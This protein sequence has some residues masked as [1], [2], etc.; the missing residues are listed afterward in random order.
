M[1]PS[2]NTPGG[3]LVIHLEYQIPAGREISP[4]EHVRILYGAVKE[5]AYDHPSLQPQLRPVLERIAYLMM[6]SPRLTHA[7]I[8]AEL[9]RILQVIAE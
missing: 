3:S 7:A 2:E 5:L 1:N 8:E 6:V 9:S 4:A